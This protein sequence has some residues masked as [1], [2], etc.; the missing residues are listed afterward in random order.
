ML[1][2][3][4][5][6]EEKPRRKKQ[7]KKKIEAAPSSFNCESDAVVALRFTVKRTEWMHGSSTYSRSV[8]V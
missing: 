4:L 3:T 7:E 1:V 2:V 6:V 8:Y 5:Q